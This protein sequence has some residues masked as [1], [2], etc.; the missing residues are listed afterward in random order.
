MKDNLTENEKVTADAAEAENEKN[1][2]AELGKFKDVQTLMKAY[3]D[4]EAEFT[5]R[6]QRLKELEKGNKADG[7]PDGAESAPSPTDEE[8]LLKS[9]LGNAR[10]RDAVIG[11]YL[12]GVSE[13]KGVPLVA[14][15]GGVSAPRNTPKSVKEAGKLAQQF[16]NS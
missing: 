3:S 4:L 16:L 9:A 8:E 12:K 11:E 15:G 1:A 7:L 10:I 5:R 2:A 13:A 6:S 14:G